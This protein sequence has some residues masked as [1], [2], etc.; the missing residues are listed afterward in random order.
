MSFN[1]E[2]VTWQSEDGTWSMGFYRVAWVDD[3][4]DEEWDVE[5]D[6]SRFESVSSGHATPDAAYDAWQGA[7]PGGT[8]IYKWSDENREAIERFDRMRDELHE[9]CRARA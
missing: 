9:R 2:N 6:H 5:Y 3:E 1:R 8:T 4:G 7:N